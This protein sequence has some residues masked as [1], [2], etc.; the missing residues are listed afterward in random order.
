MKKFLRTIVGLAIL[1]LAGLFVFVMI[2]TKP[3]AKKKTEVTPLPV[4]EFI[5]VKFE[6]VPIT[7]QSQGMV[8]AARM[9]SLAAEVG[10]KVVA[11]S[12]K[13][14]IGG[15]FEKDE[16]LIEIDQADYKAQLARMTSMLAESKMAL[17][18]EV[19]RSDLAAKDWKKLGGSGTPSD[20]TLRKP[21]LEAAKAAIQAAKADVE[22]A[23]RD[24]ERTKIRTPFAGTLEAT[25][26]EIGSYLAPGALVADLFENAPFEIRLPVSL[27]DARFVKTTEDGKLMGDVKIANGGLGWN[28]KI[29]RSEGRI[30]RSSRS[31][32]LVAEIDNA[33]ADGKPR[34]LLLQ[35]GLFA[36]AAISGKTV[37][38]A[39]KIPF[40]AFLDLK[41]VVVV[42][43]DD[44]LRFR[45]VEILRR[46]GDIVLV[47][48]GLKEGDRL[49]LTELAD[50]IEGRLVDPQPAGSSPVLTGASKA[51]S[52]VKP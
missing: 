29:V 30:D 52:E 42:D 44:K 26:T 45:E 10:G 40:P 25:A 27:D 32:H 7:I 34:S 2:K 22:K 11:V 17:A 9:T 15:R 13:F 23:K 21:Q 38:N 8:E 39:A 51:E 41:R 16:I 14:D 35:P 43:P 5:E 6:D 4:V 3:E 20:L 24:L 46:E 31:M 50:M 28:A 18:M 19:S 37:T 47:S 48:G 1:V 33:A 12:D 36:Q 49:S